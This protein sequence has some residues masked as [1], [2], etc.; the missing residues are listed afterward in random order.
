[1][2]AMYRSTHMIS[3]TEEIAMGPLTNL[4]STPSACHLPPSPKI[5]QIQ[6][7]LRFEQ[8][9]H[10]ARYTR[11]QTRT[12]TRCGK[13]M[14]INTFS[15]ASTALRLQRS[16][17]RW[18][19]TLVVPWQPKISAA[20]RRITYYSKVRLEIV[21]EHLSCQVTKCHFTTTHM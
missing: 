8:C 20:R 14:L 7:F 5:V 17:K 4:S 11:I 12:G 10:G 3:R 13:I 6:F 15:P 9:C 19:T 21:L 1:M 18:F 16:R 2:L